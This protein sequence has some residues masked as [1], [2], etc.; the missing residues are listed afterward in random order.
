MPLDTLVLDTIAAE[1]TYGFET[2]DMDRAILDLTDRAFGPGRYVKTAERLREGSK[3]L[4]Q[5]SFVARQ[6][7][8]LA[9]SVRLWPVVVTEDE[10][11]QPVVFL[12]PIVVDDVYRGLGI[13]K[14]LIRM[15]LEAADKA[16]VQAVILVGAQGFFAPFGFARAEGLTL[17]GPV[18]P[19]RLLIRYAKPGRSLRGHVSQ[20]V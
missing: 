20:G 7:Q 9:G 19:K 8:K 11:A 13:G 15:A 18:D 3:P 16:G 10:V 12:G 2:P 4:P 14:T 1:C 17:P 6:G 5:F